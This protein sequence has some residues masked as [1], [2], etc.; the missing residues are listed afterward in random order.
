MVKIIKNRIPSHMFSNNGLCNRVTR[1]YSSRLTLTHYIAHIC[2]EGLLPS[3]SLSISCARSKCARTYAKP[4]SMLVR[5]LIHSLNLY[6]SSRD[7]C[8][9]STTEIADNWRLGRVRL[10]AAANQVWW[11]VLPFAGP[12]RQWIGGFV[13]WSRPS[14]TTLFCGIAQIWGALAAA[15]TYILDQEQEPLLLL[16]VLCSCP[17]MRGVR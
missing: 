14:D 4:K 1:S 9:H 7:T 10:A 12:R 13:Q 15:S 2:Y 5:L 17:I 3:K 11:T 6:A 8:L 16:L